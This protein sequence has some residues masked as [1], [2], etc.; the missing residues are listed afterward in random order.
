MKD[1]SMRLC[2]KNHPARCLARASRRDRVAILCLA[3]ALLSLLAVLLAAGS[4]VAQAKA[5]SGSAALR[6]SSAPLDL[7]PTPCPTGIDANGKPIQSC[8]LTSSVSTCSN[9][10]CQNLKTLINNWTHW[11]SWLLGGFGFIWILVAF[12]QGAEPHYGHTAEG[13]ARRILL[14][15]FEAG[16][17]FYVA[18]RFG[19]IAVMVENV[20][21]T[22]IAENTTTGPNGLVAAPPHGAVAEL[23][24]LIVAVMV[25]VFLMYL[26]W[27][28]VYQFYATVE[29]IVSGRVGMMIPSEGGDQKIRVIALSSMLEVIALGV[30]IV[31]I[32]PILTWLF[33]YLVG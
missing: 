18:V 26:A 33:S 8:D 6:S 20:F 9:D 23:L 2:S 1:I 11:L 10:S 14:R 22:H 25:Q 31:Y 15:V 32:Q 16:V 3:I 30:G 12:Y 28:I 4:P 27:R 7:T 29:M 19:D 5:A 21:S 17:V 13:P 24:G